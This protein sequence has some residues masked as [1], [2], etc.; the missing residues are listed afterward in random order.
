MNI[1]KFFIE[2]RITTLV[3]TLVMIGAGMVSYQGLSRL[4]D[5]EF[6]IKDALVI[7]A[8]PGASA[9]EVEQE[10]SDPLEIAVQK[11][12]QVKRVVSRSERGL[13]TLTVTIK[14]KYDKFALP[15]V[16]DELRRKIGDARGE[17][18]PG[19][20]VPLVVDD[21]GD[22]YGIFVAVYGDGYS[23]AEIK[24]VADMLRRE[25]LLVDDVGKIDTFGER[26]EAIYIELRRD[27]M[28]QLGIS[29][30][31]IIGELRQKNAVANAGRVKVGSEFI[32]IEPSGGITAVDQFE[33]ILISGGARQIYLRDVANVRRGYVEPQTS[34]IRYDSF[35]AI[36]LGIS[37]VSGGNVVKMGEALRKRVEE[38]QE[39]IPVGIEAGAVSI[40][41]EAVATAISGFLISLIEAVAIVIVVLLLFMGLRSG[42]L[43]GFVLLLTIAGTFIFMAPMQVALERISLGALIIALGMLVDNAIV[44]VDGVLVRMQ[45]GQE[46]K[47]A[48]IDVVKQTALPLLGATVIAILAFAA[49][50]TSDDNTGEFCRSLF[51]VV[52]ISLLLSWVTAVSVTP[53][54]CVMFLKKP[55]EGKAEKD[56]YGSKFYSVYAGL[57]RAAIHRKVVALALVAGIFGSS[58]WGFGFVEQSFFPPSTRPQFMVDLWLPQGTHIDRTT[59]TVATVE[60]YIEQLPGV[61]HVTSLVG[62]GG[63]RFLLTYAPEKTNGAYAQLL[64][65]VENAEALDVLLPQ[66]EQYLAENYPDLL[67]YAS[68]FQLGPGSTGKIQARFSGPDR[69]VLRQLAEQTE[70]IY[71]ADYD[72]K[73]IRTDWRQRVKLV[74]PELAEEQAN[75]NGITRPDVAN[76]I[77]QA[78]QGASIGVYR[79]NDL[80]LPIVMRAEEQYRSDI[81]SMQ[82][83]QIWSPAAGAMIP[84][85]Q[86]VSGFESTFEDEIIQ[87]RNRKPT[88]TVYAD[89][90]N[91]LA[92]NLFARIR[93]DVEALQLPPGYE[94][95]WGGEYEDSGNAQAGL[96]ASLPMFLLA[97]ILITIML[98]NSLKQPLI[99]WLTVPL[100]L[101]GVT[102]GLVSTGQPFGFMALLGFLSLI[103]MLI[104][105]AIVLIDE[106]NLQWGEGKELLE[107]IVDSATSRLRPVLMAAS[108]TALGLIPLLFDAFFVSM[109]VTIIFGLGFATLLTMVVVPVLYATFYKPETARA[110]A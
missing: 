40:Q 67:G 65:D 37:T 34:L 17:L 101:I 86:V 66:V 21:Y 20:G 43:I 6:T 91:G 56:P 57:L 38:L 89:P 71:H 27:Q 74:Q 98:F 14:D 78:F 59:A 76:T 95:E 104:K 58:L 110:G 100:S 103:G 61:T 87:R 1:A 88:I 39:R 83:L 84:L 70:A 36:G 55:A 90:V 11:M 52:L 53:L 30:D 16:W 109:A 75:L 93:D 63:M 47:Q 77:L 29:E 69:D 12:G 96:I 15:Q 64:V 97:M 105:N 99:I 9:V 73:A 10:I 92:S 41:S 44:V 23:Y 7:T 72:S 51:Q 24:D 22:V 46:A 13:S 8:Y 28:S 2:Q 82:N 94:L 81:S 48:A 102:A 33:S 31:V 25:L 45:K 19:A 80:L 4:E 68:R 79:E 60:N 49:I 62:K 32:T 42:I 26:V 107:A 50:G 3:L 106:I 54:L 108:T 35:P 18:P 5:P 85:R